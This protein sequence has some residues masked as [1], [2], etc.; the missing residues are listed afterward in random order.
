MCFGSP[1]PPKIKPLPPT[2]AIDD[3]AVKAR[4]RQEQAQLAATSGRASTVT[5]DLAPSDITGTKKVL[6][7]V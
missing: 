7:G 6:L 2:P 5:S 3:D 4:Q 1:K